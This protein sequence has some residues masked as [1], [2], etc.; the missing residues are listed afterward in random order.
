MSNA[1]SGHQR[2]APDHIDY[3]LFNDIYQ[4]EFNS[5]KIAHSFV[6]LFITYDGDVYFTIKNLRGHYI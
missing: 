1:E 5:T 4:Y 2:L 6:H 3:M